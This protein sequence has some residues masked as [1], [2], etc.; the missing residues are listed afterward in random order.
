MPPE[1]I[2]EYK[3][4]FLKE[5]KTFIVNAKN[6]IL[7]HLQYM[8]CPD[9]NEFIP[10]GQSTCYIKSRLHCMKFGKE[11]RTKPKIIRNMKEK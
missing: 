5:N 8:Q 4:S 1:I 11:K 9:L 7:A 2:M 10:S 6:N 3:I